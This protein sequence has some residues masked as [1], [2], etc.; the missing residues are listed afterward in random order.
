MNG[1]EQLQF[2]NREVKGLWPQWLPAD[3]E[4]RVWMNALATLDYDPAQKA[5]QACFA[6][7]RVPARRPVLGRFLEKARTLARSTAG[8]RRA[9]R[10]P[11]TNVF[12]ECLEPPQ[13]QPH[14]IGVR[15]AVYADPPSRQCDPDY[16]LAC[17]DS[18]RQH[19]DRLYGGRW[20]VVRTARPVD[21]GSAIASSAIRGEA[22]KA[23]LHVAGNLL[24]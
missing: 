10:D 6:E 11:E 23:T 13:G 19:F 14:M 18:M 20:I 2:I 24:S 22:V 12:L 8:S 7:Q 1:T 5:V 17:A 21:D 4:V 3:A 9:A 16:L 15:K